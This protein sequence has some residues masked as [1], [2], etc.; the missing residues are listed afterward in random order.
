V[1]KSFKVTLVSFL[2]LLAFLFI[3]SPLLGIFGSMSHLL[4]LQVHS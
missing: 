1:I 2:I 3:G 4:L